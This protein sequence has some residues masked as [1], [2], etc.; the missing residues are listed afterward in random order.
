MNKYLLIVAMMVSFGVY[1]MMAQSIT[2]KKQVKRPV[3]ET[4]FRNLVRGM[5]DAWFRTREARTVA[6]SVLAYQFPG[7]GWA[8]NQA[9]SFARG[10]WFYY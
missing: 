8:K 4:S 2:E 6:D 3:S 5:D 1:P 7:G 10:Y 9:D